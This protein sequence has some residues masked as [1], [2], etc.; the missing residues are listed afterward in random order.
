VLIAIDAQEPQRLAIEK[1]RTPR[2][3][4]IAGT[5]AFDLHDFGA[6]V[7]EQHGRIRPGDRS[8]Q[9]DDPYAC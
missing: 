1:R 9:I 2:A 7:R 5:R 8:R 3:A 6:H 4:V